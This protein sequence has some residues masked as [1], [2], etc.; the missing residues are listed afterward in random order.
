M[1]FKQTSFIK[2]VAVT[3]NSPP[4]L[5]PLSELVGKAGS[6]RIAIYN[7][8]SHGASIVFASDAS[9]HSGYYI[10]NGVS[11]EIDGWTAGDI[12]SGLYLYASNSTA[13]HVTV[14]AVV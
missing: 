11:A 14:R 12:A 5:I 3:A 8:G 7:G 13:C 2:T 9:A 4:T 10:G 6:F 1:Q